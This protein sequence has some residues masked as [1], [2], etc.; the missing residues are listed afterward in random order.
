MTDFTNLIARLHKYKMTP[1][2][3]FEQSVSFAYGAPNNEIGEAN[4]IAEAEGD[5][6]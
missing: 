1:L 4:A 6:S 2:E 5:K 3:G